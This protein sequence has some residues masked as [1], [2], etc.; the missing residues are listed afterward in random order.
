MDKS[1]DKKERA[2]QA[3][4][5]YRQKMKDALTNK[6]VTEQSIMTELKEIKQLL[7]TMT[8]QNKTRK[9][10]GVLPPNDKGIE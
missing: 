2:R 1:Q 4:R 10:I 5:R 9:L 7:T 3:N 8:K 6:Q